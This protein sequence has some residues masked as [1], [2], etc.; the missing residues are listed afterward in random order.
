MKNLLKIVLSL[1]FL[2]FL[3]SCDKSE[4]VDV[5]NEILSEFVKIE[6]RSDLFDS[7]I[8]VVSPPGTSIKFS[9]NP[10]TKTQI[11]YLFKE[12]VK[13]E[14]LKLNFDVGYVTGFALYHDSGN[15]QPI[16]E[17]N[18]FGISLYDIKEDNQIVHRYFN[19]ENG[20]FIL[21]KE[22]KETYMNTENQNFLVW[23]Y[24][25]E[26]L[27]KQ[28]VYVSR[29]FNMEK[30]DLDERL[31]TTRNEFNLFRMRNKY[32]KFETSLQRVVETAYVDVGLGDCSVFSGC[33]ELGNGQCDGGYY[34]AIGGDCPPCEDCDFEYASVDQSLVSETVAEA[35]IDLDLHRQFRDDF[36]A[37]YSLGQKHI[38]YYYAVSEFVLISDYNTSTFLDM[39]ETL[40]SFN[41]SL[42]KLLNEN[43]NGS[44]ILI[45]QQLSA[46]MKSILNDF[47]EMSSNQDFQYILDD[48]IT[49]VD[50]M[51]DKTK[52][53]FILVF[54]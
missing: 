1:T 51:T 14:I 31:N 9:V 16:N 36:L 18:I 35:L 10:I 53:E 45:S 25:R 40:P 46:D 39:I 48:F 34:C 28:G 2:L 23:K 32:P 20:V 19:K 38:D 54:E 8:N 33:E 30:L 43:T 15:N 12:V 5:E 41:Q 27:D 21:K 24:N 6:L 37:N 22:L 7:S 44:D 47:K 26:K 17:E 4:V 13:K 3:S 50:L 52:D 29:T 49:D 11:T 42:N